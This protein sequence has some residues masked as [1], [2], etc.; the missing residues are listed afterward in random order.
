MALGVA[1]RFEQEIEALE[2]SITPPATA[3]VRV[4]DVQIW[5]DGGVSCRFRPFQPPP[6]ADPGANGAAAKP[7]SGDQLLSPPAGRSAV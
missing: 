6:A 5:R 2:W 3:P 1:G 7:I 4:Y